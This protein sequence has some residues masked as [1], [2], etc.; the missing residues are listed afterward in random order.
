MPAIKYFTEKAFDK[1]LKPAK[2]GGPSRKIA[3]K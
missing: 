1:A 2:L 3:Q